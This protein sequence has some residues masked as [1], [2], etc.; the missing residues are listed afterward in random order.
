[1]FSDIPLYST[2]PSILIERYPQVVSGVIS[3]FECI[4]SSTIDLTAFA[5]A[6]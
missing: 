1:M 3:I 6:A 5:K 4:G 2:H